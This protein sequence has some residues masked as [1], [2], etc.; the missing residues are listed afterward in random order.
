MKLLY[1][2]II[3]IIILITQMNC[4]YKDKSSSSFEDLVSAS[5]SDIEDTIVENINLFSVMQETENKLLD[6]IY[7]EADFNSILFCN[8]RVRISVRTQYYIDYYS[9]DREMRKYIQRMIYKAQYYQKAITNIL[10]EENAPTDLFY[11]CVHESGLNATARSH[12]GAKGWW[13]FIDNTGKNYKLRQMYQINWDERFDLEKSTRAAAKYLKYLYYSPEFGFH[14]W[15]LAIAAYNCGPVTVKNKIRESNNLKDYWQLY[16]LPFETRRYIP[17]ILA[18][19]IIYENA[20]KYNFNKTYVSPLEYDVVKISPP[21]KMNLYHISSFLNLSLDKL[22]SLNPQFGSHLPVGID[23]NLY[24]PKNSSRNF[25]EKYYNFINKKNTTDEP[26][27]IEKLYEVVD[28]ENLDAISKK[29]NIDI[30]NIYYWDRKE[31]KWIQ[32]VYKKNNLEPGEL[33]KIT[34]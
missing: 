1:L 19:K 15:L 28:G 8:Q 25:Y 10:K 32:R 9:K 20:S 7:S 23:C 24:L 34:S 3:F 16:N 5:S 17:Q 21:V 6:N 29:F 31:K 13:Q 4:S 11:I 2:Y 33:L 12:K 14:D 26:K 27:K 22:S 30:T 18:F